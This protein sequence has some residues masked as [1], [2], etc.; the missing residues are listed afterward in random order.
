MEQNHLFAHLRI[1]EN[2]SMKKETLRL[3]FGRIQDYAH[4]LALSQN[5]EQHS[6]LRAILMTTRKDTKKKGRKQYTRNSLD[7]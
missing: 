1:V 7:H 6:S 5:V 2:V 3:T 4:T